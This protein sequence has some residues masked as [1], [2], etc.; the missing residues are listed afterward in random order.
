MVQGSG[1][2]HVQFRKTKSW[3]TRQGLN[4]RKAGDALGQHLNSDNICAYALYVGM[5]F[6]YT[7]WS[8]P[9]HARSTLTRPMVWW[10]SCLTSSLRRTRAPTLPRWKMA[11]PRTSS[12]WCW[13]MRVSPPSPNRVWVCLEIQSGAWKMGC[14]SAVRK[15]REFYFSVWMRVSSPSPIAVVWRVPL[16]VNCI[17]LLLTIST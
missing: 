3:C 1:S 11:V 4:K 12:P 6:N 2:S 17:G 16:W 14:H 5:F 15:R 13:W 10:R 8:H 7:L 9:R